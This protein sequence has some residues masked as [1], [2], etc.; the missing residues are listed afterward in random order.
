M[1][2]QRCGCLDNAFL[3]NATGSK[4]LGTRD[5]PISIYKSWQVL[6]SATWDPSAILRRSPW[7][8]PSD[9]PGLVVGLVQPQVSGVGD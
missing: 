2:L 4:R 1:P 7:A 5:K 8:I 6:A 3:F 9:C